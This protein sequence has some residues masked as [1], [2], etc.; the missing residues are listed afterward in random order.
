MRKNLTIIMAAVSAAML[1]SSCGGKKEAAASGQEVDGKKIYTL[2]TWSMVNC[3]GTR[4][5][6][7]EKMGFFTEA[8]LKIIY[9]GETQPPQRIASIING[10]NDI[11]LGHP[12]LIA[13]AREGGAPIRG[14]IRS[15]I[16][17]PDSID[18]IHLQHMW[19]ISNKNGPYQSWED[20]KA[21]SD[22]GKKIK[23]QVA[24]INNCSDF[25]TDIIVDKFKLNKKNIEYITIPDV[26]GV[27]SLKRQLVDIIA[28]HPPYFKAAEE[29][30]V[31]NILI[32]SRNVAG[33]YSGTSLIYFSDK[34]INNP[35]NKEA[36]KRFV[37]AIKKAERYA[38]DNPEQASEWTAEA[39]GVPVQAN[40]YYA[41]SAVID[42]AEI[43]F[44]IDGS[45]KS[46]T[47]PADTKIKVSDVITH[48]FDQYGNEEDAI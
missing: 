37:K 48:E 47:L 33:K 14:V 2:K 29:T 18:D 27:L 35:E 31:A 8:G 25:L 40:H 7:A 23:I 30:G 22:K 38:N 45:I 19:W 1:F 39:L 9:T 15:I 28:P 34:F 3:E 44:W 20:V 4:F 17:P 32:T 13:V 11:G 16:E 43:Q 24:S 26:E 42:D 21:A 5:F 41:R 6:V 46:G 12:N 10:N 36:I